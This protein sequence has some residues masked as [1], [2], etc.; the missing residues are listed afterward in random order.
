MVIELDK[1]VEKFGERAGYVVG[2]FL[3]TTVLFFILLLL[4]KI[5]E[6]FS[7]I[8]VM[9]ITFLIAVLGVIVKRFLK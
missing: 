9:A 5:S 8:H 6:S 1:L 2:Y 4:N 7:Y 3:F